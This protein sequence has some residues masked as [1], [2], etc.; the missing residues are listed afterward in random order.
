[1]QFAAQQLV[2]RLKLART[3][4][5]RAA[6]GRDLRELQGF[7][8]TIGPVDAVQVRSPLQPA[9]EVEQLPDADRPLA[10]VGA[11]FRERVA[12]QLL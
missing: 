8:V 12:R 9:G 3:V 1:M 4:D 2:E 6:S 7:L 11:P 5:E 10:G